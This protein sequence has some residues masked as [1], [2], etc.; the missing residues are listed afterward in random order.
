MLSEDKSQVVEDHSSHSPL[1]SP[2][3]DIAMAPSSACGVAN[4]LIHVTSVQQV[5][6]HSTDATA[7]DI[8]VTSAYQRQS[9]QLTKMT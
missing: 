9:L 5:M 6:Q 8:I 4:L 2:T 7:K 1:P 3:Q